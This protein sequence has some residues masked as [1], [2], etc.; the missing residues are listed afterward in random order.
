MTIK[1]FDELV[2]GRAPD[3]SQVVGWTEAMALVALPVRQWF[4]MAVEGLPG[5]L[6]LSLRYPGE[7]PIT[8]WSECSDYDRLTWLAIVAAEYNVE[9]GY[10]VSFAPCPRK[11]PAEHGRGKAEDALCVPLLWVDIDAP[12][13]AQ[14]DQLYGMEPTFIVETGG[15]LHAYWQLDEPA[16]ADEHTK[17]VLRGLADWLGSDRA[18]A[19]FSRV[20]RV[21]GSHNTKPERDNWRVRYA[22][23][24]I[25]RDKVYSLASF[26]KIAQRLTG[27]STGGYF[28][29]PSGY[30]RELPQWAADRVAA[31][32][33]AGQRNADLFYLACVC[34]EHGVTQ[35]ECEGMFGHWIARDF[36]AAELRSTIAG[37]YRKDAAGHLRG[38]KPDR[39][40]T[41][42][43]LGGQVQQTYEQGEMWNDAE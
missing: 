28:P 5:W 19:E 10:G 3:G 36:T 35:A 31:G 42:A 43:M 37:V 27:G 24:G 29:P 11:A 32:A 34:A 13:A 25:Q 39:R 18:V 26:S 17:A 30:S 22:Q 6:E 12:T 7:A 40:M 33:P 9:R 16:A 20:M 41:G 15:G 1:W 4:A 8:L 14:V 2:E 23:G 38:L 21:V